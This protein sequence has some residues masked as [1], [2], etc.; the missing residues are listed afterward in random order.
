M[1]FL[2]VIN[3][4]SGL[5]AILSSLITMQCILNLQQVDEDHV[6]DIGEVK[7]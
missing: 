3:L 5:N 6:E 4:M 2:D 1:L 7:R